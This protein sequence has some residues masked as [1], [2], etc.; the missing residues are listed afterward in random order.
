MRT[1]LIDYLR[2]MVPAAWGFVLGLLCGL[3]LAWGV[4]GWFK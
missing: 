1:T 2:P 3:T 4:C